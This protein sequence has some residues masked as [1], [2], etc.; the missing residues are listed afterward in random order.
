MMDNIIRDIA[1]VGTEIALTAFFV[2]DGPTRLK[3]I[4]GKK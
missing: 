4:F 2:A 3:K 1:I